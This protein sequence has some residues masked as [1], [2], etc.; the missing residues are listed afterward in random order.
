MPMEGRLGVA[1]STVLAALVLGGLG[2]PA[3][4][5]DADWVETLALM[6][7]PEAMCSRTEDMDEACWPTK[8]EPYLRLADMTG[9]D[10]AP[11][12]PAI[13]ISTSPTTRTEGAD[14]RVNEDD[15]IHDYEPYPFSPGYGPPAEPWHMEIRPYLW[16]ASVGGRVTIRG[17]RSGVHRTFGE[18]FNDQRL[19][20]MGSLEYHNS[21]YLLY[22]DGIYLDF[23]EGDTLPIG[24][25]DLHIV[26]SYLT[27][28]VGRRWEKPFPIRIFAGFR[29]CNARSIAHFEGVRF[30]LYHTK[31]WF[32]PII[33]ASFHIPIR[34]RWSFDLMGDVGGYGIGSDYTWELMGLFS[35]AVG[36]HGSFQVGYRAMETDYF[37]NGFGLTTASHGPIVGFEFRFQ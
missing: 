29:Y 24:K 6:A 8:L 2:Q 28:V 7:A 21:K 11:T 1:V 4:G 37:K 13:V 36:K 5:E 33:G 17:F 15:G 23:D 12:P 22:L 35:Y 3:L 16:F 9:G 20:V 32:D 18:L 19:A 30:A 34:G 26:N 31:E 10:V 25:V 14:A 27:C